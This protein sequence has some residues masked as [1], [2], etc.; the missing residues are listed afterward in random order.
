MPPGVGYPNNG[1]GNGGGGVQAAMSRLT[2][3]EAR[4]KAQG[5]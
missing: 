1:N 2:P 4:L 3:E 5:H